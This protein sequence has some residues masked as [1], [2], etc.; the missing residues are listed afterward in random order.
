M[1]FPSITSV[2]YG[3]GKGGNRTSIQFGGQPIPIGNLFSGSN[4]PYVDLNDGNQ[5]F[6]Q[7]LKLPDGHTLQMARLL[8]RGTAIKLATDHEP[9]VV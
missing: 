8:Y 2:P 4:M 1:S 7:G 5:F 6:A 3:Q 9:V